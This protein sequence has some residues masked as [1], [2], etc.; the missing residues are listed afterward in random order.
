MHVN[1]DHDSPAVHNT[2][3]MCI[4]EV[5]RP[6]GTSQTMPCDSNTRAFLADFNA[7]VFGV[8]PW[9]LPGLDEAE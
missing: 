6:T 3:A 9:A 8:L 7:V 1:L 5:C 4:R 2:G